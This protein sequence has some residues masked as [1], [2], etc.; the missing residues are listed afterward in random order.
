MEIFR[1]S[2]RRNKYHSLKNAE[3]K[4]IKKEKRGKKCYQSKKHDM[5]HEIDHF[6]DIEQREEMLNNYSD[7]KNKEENEN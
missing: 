4:E 7:N 1:H 6:L 5:Y 2:R 3:L